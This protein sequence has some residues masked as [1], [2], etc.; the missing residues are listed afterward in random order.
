MRG[1]EETITVSQHLLLQVKNVFDS[2]SSTLQVELH[3][4]PLALLA[5]RVTEATSIPSSLG[6]QLERRL[7]SVN[8]NLYQLVESQN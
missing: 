2:D 8:S 5:S 1:D 4:R 6:V 7:L 3:T